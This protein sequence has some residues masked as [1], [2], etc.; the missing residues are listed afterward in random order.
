MYGSEVRYSYWNLYS[1]KFPTD[2]Q[3]FLPENIAFCLSKTMKQRKAWHAKNNTSRLKKAYIRLGVSVSVSF[4]G[5]R[6]SSFLFGYTGT[7]SSPQSS[8]SLDKLETCADFSGL[9]IVFNSEQEIM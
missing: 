7:V 5:S 4:M 1:T 9:Y 2:V 6:E 3:A 8:I